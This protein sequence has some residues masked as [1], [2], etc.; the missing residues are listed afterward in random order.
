MKRIVGMEWVWMRD[1]RC[2]VDDGEL[3]RWKLDFRQA[4]ARQACEAALLT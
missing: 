3:S 1:C 4:A 2:G